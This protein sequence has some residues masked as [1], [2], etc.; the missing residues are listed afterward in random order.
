MEK[1]GTGNVG[2]DNVTGRAEL[3]R[4]RLGK[5]CKGRGPAKGKGGGSEEG[6]GG[7][8]ERDGRAVWEEKR[9]GER[10]IGMQ[11]EL[12][13]GGSMEGGRESREGKMGTHWRRGPG[14]ERGEDRGDSWRRNESP[15]RSVRRGWGLRAERLGPARERGSFQ[16]PSGLQRLV[17]FA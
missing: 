13:E 15:N 16:H 9:A 7:K 8:A 10:G 17:A 14:L 1:T 5:S 12:G 3:K 11:K 2:T 4:N 6:E